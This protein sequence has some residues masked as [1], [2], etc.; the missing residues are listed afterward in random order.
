MRV[1]EGEF[2]SKGDWGGGGK[3]SMTEVRGVG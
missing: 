1:T 2:V 3:V